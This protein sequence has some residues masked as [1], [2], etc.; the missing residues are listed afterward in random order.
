MLDVVHLFH[1]LLRESLQ[2]DPPVFSLIPCL[3]DLS[4]VTDTD[5]LIYLKISDFR[6]VLPFGFF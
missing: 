1:F 3:V 2:G 6:L 4:E 5:N